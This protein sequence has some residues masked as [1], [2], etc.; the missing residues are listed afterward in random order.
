MEDVLALSK[1]YGDQTLEKACQVA[2][3]YNIHSIQYIE[4][5]IKTR[6]GQK[7][8]INNKVGTRAENPYLRGISNIH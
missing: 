2:H 7:A 6:G 1:R 5:V 3:L 8:S 4:R